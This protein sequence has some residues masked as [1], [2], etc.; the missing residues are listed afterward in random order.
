[1]S[2]VVTPAS[3]QGRADRQALYTVSV[4]NAGEAAATQVRVSAAV[5][6]QEQSAAATGGG[7]TALP[8]VIPR[9][10][11]GATVT[12]AVTE[13]LAGDGNVTIIL[14][15]LGPAADPTPGDNATSLRVAAPRRLPAL[16]IGLAAAVAAA[17]LGG[18][19]YRRWQKL[20]R[21]W[22]DQTK[23]TAE[24]GP[25]DGGAEPLTFR[26]PSVGL[27]VRCALG[28]GGPTAPIPILKVVDHE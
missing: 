19:R 4:H 7:C 12:F 23:V 22:L 3:V 20:K 21:F 1:M 2:I 27:T 15:A 13:S 25:V 11:G 28:E 24:R 16:P 5:S 9:I 26:A 18:W 17:A 10:P 8:C 14:Q 6:G